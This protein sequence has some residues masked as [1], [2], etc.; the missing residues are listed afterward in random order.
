MV[1]KI[2]VGKTYGHET[3]NKAQMTYIWPSL[4]DFVCMYQISDTV[5]AVTK[6]GKIPLTLG[7][8]HS[9]SIGTVHGHAMAEPNM[10]LVWVDAHS[11]INTP[12]ASPSGNIHGMVLSFLARELQKYVPH[13]P[14]ME[15][16]KPWWVKY[17]YLGC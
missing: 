11:D 5:A 9:L 17:G 14:G 7:G 2:T 8:D 6:E 4:P 13:V 3:H 15:W 12:L 10:C 16:V 1:L